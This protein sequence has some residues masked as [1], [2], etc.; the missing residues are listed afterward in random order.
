MTAPSLAITSILKLGGRRSFQSSTMDSINRRP[1]SRSMSQFSNCK[2][3]FLRLIDSSS[4]SLSKY[5]DCQ[6]HPPSSTNVQRQLS[7]FMASRHRQP[8]NGKMAKAK[9]DQTSNQCS[10]SSSAK[11]K[12]STVI[13]NRGIGDGEVNCIFCKILKNEIP[14]SIVYEDTICRI[15]MDINPIVPGHA[16]IIPRRHYK[17]FIGSNNDNSLDMPLEVSLHMTKLAHQLTSALTTKNDDEM[18]N[19]FENTKDEDAQH[20]SFQGVNLLWN[21]GRPAWQTI[22]HTHLHVI[23]RQKGDGL[24]FC[25]GV[26]RHILALAGLYPSAKKHDLDWLATTFSK[27]LKKKIEADD[28][29]KRLS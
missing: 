19:I 17:N 8:F 5:D 22:M 11:T 25:L 2:V 27:R 26:I 6:Y 9:R 15:I 13:A 23:P 21:H 12:T 4:S 20:A 14:S 10:N 18:D 1:S 7:T 3:T 24:Y 28:N 16:L 29:K